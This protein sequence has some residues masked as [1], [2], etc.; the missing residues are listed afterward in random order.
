MRAVSPCLRFAFYML[1]FM[2]ASDLMA[3]TVAPASVTLSEGATQQFTANTAVNWTPSCGT[4]SSTGLYKAP[5]YAKLCTVTAT[6]TDGSGSGTASANVVSPIVMT[7]SGVNTPLGQTQQFT[8]SSPVVWT[9][10]CGTITTGG[11][12]TATLP[13][14]TYCTIKA[15]AA[16]GTP[17]VVYGY[18]KVV[19]PLTNLSIAPT[20]ASIAEGG[21][22]QFTS[23][24]GAT[25]AASC[26]SISASGLY[27]GP[28]VATSCTVTAT[29]TNGSGQVASATVAI[30]SPILI[31]PGSTTTTQGLTQQFTANKAVIW[32]S[33]CGSITAGG[34]FTASASPGS[35]CLITATASSGLAYT[36]S[37][38]DTIG[39]AGPLT[40]TPTSVTLNEGATQ[41]FTA[42]NAVTWTP[43]CGTIS[44][45]GLYKAPLYA[46]LC[47]VTATAT[48]GGGS[49]T[50]NANVVSPIVMTP[51]G[52]N[53]PL[54]QTQQFTASSPV[55][56]TA[57]CGAITASGLFTATSPV[58]TYCTIKAVAASGTPYVVYGY[59][60]V[61]AAVTNLAITPTS[62]S[63]SEGAT[64]QFTSNIG[65]TWS[66]SCGS[67]TP[68]TGFY[69]APLVPASCT[70]T[71]TAT[72]GTGQTASAVVGVSSPIVITPATAAT[73][74]FQTQQFTASAPVNWSASCGSITA[75]GLF[76]ASANPGSI[77]TVVATAS[78]GPAYTAS[79]IDTVGAAP[80]LTVAPLMPTVSEAG[81][82]QFTANLPATWSTNCGSIDA[83]AGLFTAGLAPGTCTVT[84]TAANGSV[85]TTITVTSPITITASSTTTAQFQTQQFS[86][87]MAVN[88]SASCG[89][90]SSTGLFTASAPPGSM[91]T[92]TAT[93]TGSPAYTA[94]VVDTVG[95]S[96]AL[97]ITPLTPTVSE[98]GTQQFTAN[99]PV[100]WSASC[101]SIDTNAGLFTAALAAGV[102]GVTATTTDGSGQ[103]AT[104]NATVTS[105]INITPS[106]PSTYATARLPFTANMAV[107]WST[108]CG[109]I[110]PNSGVFTAPG[111]AASCVVTATAST[112]TAFTAQATVTINLVHYTTWKNDISRTGLQPKEFVLTP[113]NVNTASFG[114]V[115]NQVVDG[116]IWGQPLYMN[117]L[118]LG[119]TLHNVVFITTDNDSVYAFDADNGTQLWQRTFLSNGVTPIPGSMVTSTM[120]KIG[121]VGTPV[122]DPDAGVLYVV[123]ATLEN[124]GTTLVHRLHSIDVKTGLDALAGSAVISDA[125]FTDA[126]EM[127]RAGLLLAN[128][129]VYVSFGGIGDI[130][131]YHG[132]VFAFDENTLAQTAVYNNTLSGNG[133]GIW[134][135]S[136]AP[137]ADEDGNVYVSSGNG[138][139]DSTRNLSESVIKL[140]PSLQVLDFFTPYNQVQ[141]E[142]IDA[143]LGSGGVL[144]VPDQTGAYVHE[145]INC[146][147][148]TPIYVMNRDQMGG[149]NTTSDNV[150]QRLDNQLGATGSFRDSGM[151]CFLTPAMWKQN[152][153]F[154][155]NHDV[156]KT[157]VLDPSSGLLSGTPVATGSFTYLWPGAQ[158]AISSNG[159]TNGVLW[160]FDRATG[161][162]RANDATNVSN[163]LYI[164]GAMSTAGKWP[165]PTVVNGHVYVGVGSVI[166]AFG[167]H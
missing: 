106:G 91:C 156:I 163:V 126:R 159:D 70:V 10:S 165:V 104:T 135:S 124:S 118:N 139:Y 49:A 17:Y 14:G 90:I 146:G 167:S 158:P 50:A 38:V 77:C 73:G 28:L 56:W 109:N 147:K 121:M 81:T 101:G 66:A 145:L 34:L 130:P 120:A 152:V 8:A 36:A 144:I 119:G 19:A 23:T 132:Y 5:L 86:A 24:V 16:S 47:T 129:T 7:P 96:L 103:T 142:P 162:L 64:Q 113:T 6:A 161:T 25:W 43:S 164:S 53:T 148:P 151:P 137:S 89:S 97:A 12:F 71:A 128:H 32:T 40:V 61:I 60:K 29:A 26:G 150:I 76:T 107:N 54:G 83:N 105:P 65:A 69:S 98:G 67:I 42:S 117:A 143:D 74:Q 157:F 21:T 58:G 45:S 153:Y 39:A 20:S 57:S 72:N 87:N 35:N 1:L 80:S 15:V 22:Q 27:T 11:L 114:S 136:G 9:A 100:T 108:S 115:W 99:M 154:I 30:T 37:V 92:I 75:G 63:L 48:T 149:Y 33:S 116:V 78:G 79:A 111:T 88:W 160:T 112:G 46:K 131:P 84:A 55:V 82:Q 155:A 125:N 2:S 93:A 31:T 94:T 3:V 44:A 141:L 166:T 85:S 138:Y 62:A 68:T 134:M 140:S 52:I 13:V 127:Q 18:D 95:G 102:C 110:D 123:V 59:D 122:I 133:G 4:I 41:Q 51:S